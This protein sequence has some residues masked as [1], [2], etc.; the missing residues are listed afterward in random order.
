M[1]HRTSMAFRHQRPVGFL[2]G[3]KPALVDWREA[4]ERLDGSYSPHK[5]L[6]Y[7]SDFA[8]FE[9]WCHEHSLVFLPAN[10]STVVSFIIALTERLKPS[11]LKRKLAGI[12][13]IHHLLRLRDPTRDVDVDLLSVRPV[14][15]NR[16]G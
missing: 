4:L 2:L 7:R 13:K 12:R 1:K 8:S 15:S 3:E 6:S 16:S 5:L 9:N 10:P 11:S 14:A